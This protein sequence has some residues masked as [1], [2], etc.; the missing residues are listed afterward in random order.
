MRAHFIS[1]ENTSQTAGIE[2]T[3][4][5]H[6]ERQGQCLKAL[7]L[8]GKQKEIKETGIVHSTPDI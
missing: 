7:M 6:P 2:N 4:F 5:L 1:W 3:K 8:I